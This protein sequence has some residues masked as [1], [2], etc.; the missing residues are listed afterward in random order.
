[1]ISTRHWKFTCT[2]G[3]CLPCSDT[4]KMLETHLRAQTKQPLACSTALEIHFW[5]QS[6]QDPTWIFNQTLEENWSS[7]NSPNRLP[8]VSL[9]VCPIRCESLEQLFGNCFRHINSFHFPVRFS[10]ANLPTWF[11]QNVDRPIFTFSFT[12]LRK[13]HRSHDSHKVHG[14]KPI[15]LNQITIRSNACYFTA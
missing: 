2:S 4:P 3:A 6:W 9:Q 13:S 15:W 10:R 11:V 14:S 8:A 5:S 1:M 12:G 7:Q